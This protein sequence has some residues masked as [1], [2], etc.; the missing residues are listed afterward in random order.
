MADLLMSVTDKLTPNQMTPDTNGWKGRHLRAA[1]VHPVGAM[2]SALDLYRARHNARFGSLLGNDY[3]L[4]PAFL[5]ALR[6]VR[7]MLNG[8]IGGLDGG[9]CDAAIC[10]IYSESGFE[11]EL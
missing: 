4:G 7:T 11:G 3:V 10:A 1:R 2:I 9:T 6:G 5:D 8:E